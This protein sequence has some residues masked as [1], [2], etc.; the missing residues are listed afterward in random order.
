MPQRRGAENR[1]GPQRTHCEFSAFLRVSLRLCVEIILLSS[2][3]A[4]SIARA[5]ASNPREPRRKLAL[6]F[7]AGLGFGRH[8]GE[9]KTDAWYP[10]WIVLKAN[11]TS[12]RGTLTIF[13]EDNPLRV[14]MPFEVAK[15]ATKRFRAAFKLLQWDNINFQYSVVIDDEKLGREE[16]PI[17]YNGANEK[18]HHVL[19]LCDDQGSFGFLTRRIERGKKDES[20]MLEERRAIYGSPEMLPDDPILLETLDAIVVSTSDM[21]KISPAAWKALEAW[22]WLGGRLLLAAGKDHPFLEGSALRGAFGVDSA[23]PEPISIEAALGDAA[24]TTQTRVLAS[25]PANP[26]QFWDKTWLGPPERPLIAGKRCGDGWF[27]FSSVAL[28]EPALAAINARPGAADLWTAMLERRATPP[29]LIRKADANS[30]STGLRLQM[31]FGVALAGTLWVVIFLASYV[32][33]AVPFNWWICA[34][35]KRREWAWGVAIVLALSFSLYGYSRGTRARARSVEANQI[36]F[37][38]R[39]AGSPVAR[40]ASF[41]S[42]FSPGRYVSSMQADGLIYPSPLGMGDIQDPYGRSR[43][44]LYDESPLRIRFGSKTRVEGF[45]IYPMSARDLRS[46]FAATIPGGIELIPPAAPGAPIAI[47]NNTPWTFRAW[48]LTDGRRNWQGFNPSKPIEPGK[49]LEIPGSP[50]GPK[51]GWTDMWDQYLSM[52]TDV[53]MAPM[54][55]EVD[56]KTRNRMNQYYSNY[57]YGYSR[58]E[59]AASPAAH[60]IRFMGV[61]NGDLSP[62]VESLG[63]S[64]RHS[65]IVYEESLDGAALREALWAG[66]PPSA[67]WN[68]RLVSP[69]LYRGRNAATVWAQVPYEASILILSP[70]LAFDAAR[71]SAVELNLK[72]SFPSDDNSKRQMKE[73]LGKEYS[74]AGCPLKVFNPRANAWEDRGVW[75]GE[76][77][78][79]DPAEDYLHPAFSTITIEVDLTREKIYARDEAAGADAAPSLATKAFGANWPPIY[80]SSVGDAKV[81]V[82]SEPQTQPP[83]AATTTP[84]AEAKPIGGA[85]P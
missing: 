56:Q 77:V 54:V 81:S 28:D 20:G 27:H 24:G 59:L 47:K 49:T 17:I 40:V 25:W 29:D 79:L 8:Q 48:F 43:A 45:F 35:L 44:D 61:A 32:L 39:P 23:K 63:V 10:A 58:S 84:T 41:A 78:R 13:Q 21:K 46:D 73:V 71:G 36:A 18:D 57:G 55:S 60:P 76:P 82:I 72:A 53:A 64:K 69:D 34:R 3:V 30:S 1:G 5:Q 37:V 7:D 12:A 38:S 22:V 4:P 14:S 19:I 65:A 42:V 62:L 83:P 80:W 33:L 74:L 6:E 75:M 16:Y 9:V 52:A 50:P 85:A 68:I 66:D 51:H 15:G 70:T 26:P 2:F 11:E 67:R 31:A